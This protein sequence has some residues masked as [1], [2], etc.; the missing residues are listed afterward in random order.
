MN[1]KGKKLKEALRTTEGNLVCCDC[2]VQRNAFA[3]GIAN[4]DSLRTG[5]ER[6]NCDRKRVGVLERD[7]CRFSV[8]GEANAV[9]E[10]AA[11]NRKGCSSSGRNCG[12]LDRTDAERYG[13]KLNNSER[14]VLGGAIRRSDGKKSLAVLIGREEP[15]VKV[16]HVGHELLREKHPQA[17]YT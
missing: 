2:G 13:R 3:V 1:K 6:G 7:C 14:S 11:A 4:G 8:D 5:G 16:V 9:D 17:K 10:T 15:A 12:W